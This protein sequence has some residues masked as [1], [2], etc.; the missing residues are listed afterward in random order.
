MTAAVLLTSAVAAATLDQTSKVLVR[1]RLAEARLHA[2]AGV[3][4]RRSTNVRGGL[5][6]LSDRVALIVWTAVVACVGLAV[7]LGSPLPA[8]AAAGLGLALGGAF[9]NLVDRLARGGVVDFIAVGR[10]PTFNLADAAMVVGTGLAVSS[11]L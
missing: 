11:L 5:L 2:L 1:S 9:G 7:V 10:W 3:G 6:P 4:F 8:T